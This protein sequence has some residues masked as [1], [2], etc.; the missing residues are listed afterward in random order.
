M[1]ALQCLVSRVLLIKIYYKKGYSI[2]RIL[3][4]FI[5]SCKCLYSNVL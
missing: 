2:I 1:R 5:N 3:F 4:K